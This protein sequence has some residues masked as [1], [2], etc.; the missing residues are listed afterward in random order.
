MLMTP[1]HDEQ[2]V[3]QKVDLISESP[4][5]AKELLDCYNHYT[6]K[7]SSASLMGASDIPGPK[8]GQT[9]E[10]H[11]HESMKALEE[12]EAARRAAALE[13]AKV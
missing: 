8:P 11:A 2:G 4:K 7:T 12:A 10:E 9:A 5:D 1:Y 13:P 6:G 3:L